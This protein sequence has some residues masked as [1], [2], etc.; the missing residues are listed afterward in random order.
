MPHESEGTRRLDCDCLAHGPGPGPEGIIILTRFRD[1]DCDIY[2]NYRRC[3]NARSGG[4]QTLHLGN[5]IDDY[6]YEFVNDAL[7]SITSR[8]I[9]LTTATYMLE[10]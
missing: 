8:L 5:S 10:T 3:Q 1:P 2:H 7:R 6:T 4:R 9:L